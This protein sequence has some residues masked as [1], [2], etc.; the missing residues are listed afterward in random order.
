MM[1]VLPVT[2]PEMD[3]GRTCYVCQFGSAP[4]VAAFMDP[5]L[6]ERDNYIGYVQ[7]LCEKNPV[8]QGFIV[9]LSGPNEELIREL[10]ALAAKKNLSVPLT[11]LDPE[12]GLPSGI[13]LSKEENL[14]ILFYR[15]RF[16]EK[17]LEITPDGSTKITTYLGSETPTE[18]IIL[19]K[20]TK[21]GNSFRYEGYLQRYEGLPQAFMEMDSAVHEMINRE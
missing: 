17:K 1:W 9:L 16:F 15:K 14:T 18:E 2:G 21:T 8:L 4:V 5:N 10:K 7:L 19:P 20:I 11:V 3:R 6:Q 13:P 12:V